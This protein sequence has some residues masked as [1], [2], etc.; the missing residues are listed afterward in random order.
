M[1]EMFLGADLTNH[2]SRIFFIKVSSTDS[3]SKDWL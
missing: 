1:T 2:L 3:H